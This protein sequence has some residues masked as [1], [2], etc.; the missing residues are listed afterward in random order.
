MHKDTGLELQITNRDS[1]RL[2]FLQPLELQKAPVQIHQSR[3]T[4]YF[5]AQ[6]SLGFP[7]LS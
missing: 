6:D 7:L 1:S 5:M 3:F 2:A 4:F